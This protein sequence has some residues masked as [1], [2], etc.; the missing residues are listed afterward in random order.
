[1]KF[2]LRKQ[3]P[4]IQGVITPKEKLQTLKALSNFKSE[5]R[6]YVN[7]KVFLTTRVQS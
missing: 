4:L 2:G 1:M 5:L 6:G 7:V 3:V